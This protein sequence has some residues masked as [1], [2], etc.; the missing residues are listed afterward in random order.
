MTSENLIARPERAAP[1]RTLFRDDFAAGLRADGEDAP[2]LLKP[3]GALA[4]GDG[5]PR[6][7]P[8]EGLVV[9][10]VGVHSTTGEPCFAY[11]ATPGA[12]DDH[13]L[14][15]AIPRR[16]AASGLPGHDIGPDGALTVE[17]E[18]ATEA[19]GMAAHPYGDAV[20]DPRGDLRLGAGA[21]I[22]ADVETRLVLNLSLTDS[23]VLALYERFS[24]PGKKNGFCRAVPVA[25]RV[26]G[27]FHRLAI[28]YDRA[29]G[30]ARWRVDGREVLR[31]D[32]IGGH[33]P[34]DRG[35][36]IDEG[37][38]EAD[39][40]PRQLLTGVCVFT[41]PG[42]SGPDGG[43]ALVSEDRPGPLGPW[44]QGVRLAAR[45]FE[46]TAH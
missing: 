21:L 13:M 2:W 35:R 8:G 26:P 24:E 23:R 3:A 36:L 4:Q 30:T 19:F 40:S 28:T 45:S 41:L 5:V 39:I 44:G 27:Q 32:R 16:F 17:A 31:V 7:V 9:D 10:P 29:A 37:A 14:W 25:D 34:S 1:R 6:A 38:P 22:A 46:V 33:G 42:A 15:R 12:G 11:G 43:P 18:I 20:T